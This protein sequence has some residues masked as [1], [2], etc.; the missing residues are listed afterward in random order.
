MSRVAEHTYD[1][2][3][4]NLDIKQN[5]PEKIAAG[6]T[7]ANLEYKLYAGDVRLDKDMLTGYTWDATVTAPDGTT[8]PLSTNVEGTDE[9]PRLLPQ[10]RKATVSTR[11]P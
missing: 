1:Y 8:A 2:K 3:A 10:L 5:H 4:G 6:A 9:L 7:S 11:S